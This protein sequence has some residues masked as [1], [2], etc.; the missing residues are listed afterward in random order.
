MND[1]LGGWKATC[2]LL[3]TFHGLE[4]AQDRQE[5]EKW[6]LAQRCPGALP[7]CTRSVCTLF[8]ATCSY[9]AL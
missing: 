9:G 1:G 6:S 7:R 3:L 8:K 4:R 2:A 5:T